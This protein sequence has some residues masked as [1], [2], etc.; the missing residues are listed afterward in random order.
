MLDT[1]RTVSQSSRIEITEKKSRF[2]GFC[3]PLASESEALDFVSGSR[4][5][6]PDASHHVYAWI[7]GGEQ[8]L[9]RFSDDGEPQGTAGKPV[10]D[11]LI[12]NCILQAGIVVVRYFGGTLLGSGGL[13]RTYSRAAALALGAAAPVTMQLCETFKITISYTGLDHL[14]RQLS[15]AGALLLDS[16]FGM[17]AELIAAVPRGNGDSFYKICADASR[18]AA[19]VEPAGFG[20]Q[21][22][23]PPDPP[24]AGRFA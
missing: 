7:L 17:D 3:Q 10:I 22:L 2:L 12:H 11:I 18:G 16:R 19:L 4:R 23:P 14:R 20:Y 24:P 6:F 1:Y 5:D 21:M 15:Q 9:Q 13:A 8:N